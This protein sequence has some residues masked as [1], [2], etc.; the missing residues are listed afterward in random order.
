[1]MWRSRQVL[2]AVDDNPNNLQLLVEGLGDR[3]EIVCSL[4][5][6]EALQLIE[7][8][9]P[10]LILLDIQM[11]GMSGYDVCQRVREHESLKDIP[12]IFLTAMTQ[13]E[14]ELKGLEQG[15]VDYITKPFDMR[16][17]RLRVTTQMTLRKQTRM[18][19]EK[20]AKLEEAL[21]N[22]RMM[23]EILPI[24]MYCK[25]IR[26]DKGYWEQ[27]EQY[28]SVHTGSNFSHGVCPECM[29]EHF[30]DELADKVAETVH[31]HRSKPEV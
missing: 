28:I 19:Q 10:D 1:M 20:T 27:L 3:Y 2:V 31:H 15:A 29:R 12:I 26:D 4:N 23:Q 5:G 25:K 16:I 17:V 6:E 30:G 13:P 18:L 24:C 21:E 8:Y 22:I 9:Q 11:P 7:A 14:D